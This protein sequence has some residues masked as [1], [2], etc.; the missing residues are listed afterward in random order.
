[1]AIA[2]LAA[3]IVVVIL[4]AG[5]AVFAVK[6]VF[7]GALSV[8]VTRDSHRSMSVAIARQTLW[9]L[10]ETRHALIATFS[11]KVL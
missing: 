7:T 2:G 6:V 5:I 11:S 1:M 10:V 4:L 9:E 8:G 3:R